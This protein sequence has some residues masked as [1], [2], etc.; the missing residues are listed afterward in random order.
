MTSKHLHIH[1]FLA[2]AICFSACTQKPEH[3]QKVSTSVEIYP[4]YGGIVAPPNIA[5]LNFAVMD[6]ADKHYVEIIGENGTKITVSGKKIIDIPI[7]KW[8]NLLSENKGKGYIVNIFS[9]KNGQWI[10]YPEIRNQIAEEKL[11]PYLT[12]RLIEPGYE[13]AG[14]L[15]IYQR[16][17]EDFKQSV[18]VDNNL[19]DGSCMNCHVLCWND[20]TQT[21]MHFRFTNSG[22]ILFQH[23]QYKRLNTVTKEFTNPGIHP[24]WH[25][26]G[27][28]IAFST[29]TAELFFHSD[30]HKRSESYDSKGNIAVYDIDENKW[31]GVPELMSDEP[32]QE[33]FP[34]WSPDGK[35]LYF[36]RRDVRKIDTNEPM[37]KYLNVLQ[38]DLMRIPFDIETKTFGKV[39]KIIDHHKIGKSVSIPRVSPD[40]KYILL[41]IADHGTFTVWHKESDLYT[42]NVETGELKPMT[43]ANSD[44]SDSY[45]TWSSNGRWFVVSSKRI[46]GLFSRPYFAY[47][48]KNGEVHKAFIMPQ[49]DPFFY[50]TFIK[51]YNVPELAKGKI[52]VDIYELAKT[53]TKGEI[54]P[55]E[56][57]PAKVDTSFRFR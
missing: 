30:V 21:V 53:V 15:G 31:L 57:A 3:A 26:T 22:T 33:T 55:V 25:P 10:E 42:Y 19:T 28:F 35:Y 43:A 16:C 50:D 40:G 54:I 17:L 9:K 14:F 29:N 5:P 48:D 13:L 20:P 27:K 6:S 37:V 24:G 32:V 38:Y 12:Y 49:K 4:D 11:D 34:T 47:F 44:E 36:C 2:F 39:E 56:Y 18:I 23:G 7:K 1:L 46:D 45:H 51:S 41:C 8:K 52:P